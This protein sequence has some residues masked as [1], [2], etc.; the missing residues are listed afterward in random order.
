MLQLETAIETAAG[1]DVCD[2]EWT[3]SAYAITSSAGA[4]VVTA[5]DAGFR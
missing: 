5:V 3:G 4:A 1:S 2:V